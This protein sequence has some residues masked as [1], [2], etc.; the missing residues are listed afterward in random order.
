[1]KKIFKK[2][3]S[4]IIFTFIFTIYFIS[5]VG[6]INSGDTPQYFTTEAIIKNKNL[7]MSFFKDDPHF[8]V[9]PDYFVK[10]NQILNFRGWL[11]SFISIPFHY[12]AVILKTFLKTTLFARH[13]NIVKNFAYELAIVSTLSV[14]NVF[15]LI[16]IW[17]ILNK[18]ANKKISTLTTLIFAFGTYIWKYAATYTRSIFIVFINGLVIYSLWS[19]FK[20][21]EKIWLLILSISVGIVFGI[22]LI[23]FFSLIISLVLVFTNYYLYFFLK[24]KNKKDKKEF[25][26]GLGMS[27]LIFFFI[28]IVNIFFNY[29]YYKKITFSNYEKHIF[30]NEL[31]E[32]E[33]N[34]FLF[35]APIY[36]TILSIL[37][38]VGK[39]PSESFRHFEKAPSIIGEHFSLSYA[40]KYN[41]FGLFTITPFALLGFLSL[42]EMFL[43]KNK[44]LKL[45]ICFS[46]LM[47]FLQ[48]LITTKYFAFYAANQYDVRYFY[49][50]ILYLAIPIALALKK[51]FNRKVFFIFTLLLS[52][53]S[54]FMGWLGVINM[55]KPALTGERRIWMDLYDVP[56]NFFKYSFQD[57]LDATF[58]NRENFWVPILLSISGFVFF[59][60]II[61]LTK[62]I[63]KKIH[64]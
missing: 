52:F 37:F 2:N 4:V 61:F 14:W 45:I 3:F 40:K 12:L 63:K 6:L 19:Y 31:S 44:K 51:Y 48:I 46:F 64:F 5:S 36:P 8:F 10:D 22:D 34:K 32:K 11:F 9:W 54:I 42:K 35:S 13:I 16:L 28:I 29:F 25:F 38:G 18:I 62:R 1:M 47:F 15:G 33:K 27:F 43:N 7:D 21:R 50:Y 24:N 17:M 20:K 55:Y 49:P 58:L 39:L 53:F 56:Q 23:L 41:F 30:F 26:I 57:Y 60:L 59:K